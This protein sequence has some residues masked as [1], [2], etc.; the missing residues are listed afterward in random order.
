MPEKKTKMGSKTVAKPRS[1][2]SN[3]LLYLKLWETWLKV[4]KI[5]PTIE[6]ANKSIK[7]GARTVASVDTMWSLKF[8]YQI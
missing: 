6:D 7:M 4:P 3:L 1:D 8:D 2:A 5:F